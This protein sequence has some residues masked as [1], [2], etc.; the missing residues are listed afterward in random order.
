MAKF[1]TKLTKTIVITASAVLM[2]AAFILDVVEKSLSSYGGWLTMLREIVVLTAFLLF[3]FFIESI[4]KREQSS[5]KKFG[6]ALVISLVVIVG[7]GFLSIIPSSGFDVKNY[8]LDP[9]GFDAI[10][11]ANVFSVVIGTMSIII[12]L[13]IRDIIFSKRKKGTRR[14]FLSFIALALASALFTFTLRPLES[15]IVTS[16]LLGLTVAAIVANSF[17]LSWIVY[18][19]KR[20][21]LFNIVYGFLLLC[22]FIGFDILMTES[23]IIGKSVAYHSPSLK[24]FISS[25]TLFATVYFGMTFVS[26]LFHLPTAE[27]FDRKSSE[28]SSLHNLSRLVTQVFD[29][30]E[31]VDSVTTMTL[32]VC[33]AKSSW[34]E[35]MKVSQTPTNT[36]R[37]L[38]GVRSVEEEIETVSRKNISLDDT[39]AIMNANGESIRKLALESK[40][41]IIVDEVKNDKRTQHLG[42]LGTKFESIIIVPLV[43]H[44]KVIGVLYATKDMSFGFD[45][46]DVEVITAFADQAT[47]A[48]E[49]SRLIEKSLERERLMREMILAQDMQRKLLPQKLP[50]LAEVDLEALSTPA[51]EVGGDYYDFTMLDEHHLAILVGD[52]SGKGV[53]AAFYMA[54]MKGIFQSIS[55]IYREPRQF[56]SQAHA[57]LSSTID[58]RSFISLLYTVLDLRT[59][60]MTVA[61]AG[62]CPLLHVTQH[63]GVF[64]KPTGLGLGMGSSEFFE[65]TIAQEQIRLCA[66]DVVVMYTDGVTEAH[67]KSGD[68]FGYERLL[69]VVEKSGNKSAVEVRDAIIM[70]VD[71]HMHHE[72]PEDDLTIVVLKWRKD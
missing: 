69:Q 61:R 46:D 59:G 27:A 29:F 70:A 65:R 48:I 50:A 31:L 32:E 62:H 14:N 47:I 63:K 35:I 67:T 52:V 42:N 13:L 72:S 34:L 26:T 43:T 37:L 71:S 19:T 28:V 39:L 8:V 38:G 58:K 17:R 51:F 55:K 1:K 11:W 36:R 4:W 21:K 6:F 2:V 30:E 60:L 18:L 33:E 5:A 25:V 9:L 44:D 7:A 15:N 40:K 49:N 64:I 68:E 10:V 45:R 24:S 53:S 57:A 41:A 12:L 16:L 20:E 56:L 3:Y 66:N 54:E 22:I 23:I